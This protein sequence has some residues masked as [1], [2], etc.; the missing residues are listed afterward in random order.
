MTRDDDTCPSYWARE[1]RADR[2]V[3]KMDPKTA[4]PRRGKR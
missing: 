2:L 3:A 1:S 4:G